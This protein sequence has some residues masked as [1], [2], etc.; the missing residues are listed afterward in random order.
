MTRGYD[1]CDYFGGEKTRV[2][3]SGTEP[4]SGP[5]TPARGKIR[6]MKPL[7]AFVS[8]VAVLTA[9][10]NATPTPE[11]AAKASKR[12]EDLVI[13]FG[14]FLKDGPESEKL[15]GVCG[16]DL[17]RNELNC[18]IYNGLLSWNITEVTFEITWSPYQDEEKRFFRNR[19]S[20]PPMTT[21]HLSIKL[22]MQ[23]PPDDMIKTRSNVAP[24]HLRHWSWLI[25]G[26]KG[27]HI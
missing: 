4:T 13:T 20:I 19:V 16:T 15:D 23:L 22:G 3:P 6:A 12:E 25:A 8:F 24:T 17:T 21:S 27:E 5:V 7:L 9:C 14:G 11:T 2:P 1:R 26:A 18:D 10:N